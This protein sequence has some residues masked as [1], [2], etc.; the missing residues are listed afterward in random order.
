L[1]DEFCAKKCAPKDVDAEEDEL[2]TKWT[3]AG[4]GVVL[5]VY[6]ALGVGY[7]L[8]TPPWQNPDEPAHYNYVAQA[9]ASGCCPV[10]AAGDWDQDYLSILTAN[11][12]DP[13][14]LDRLDS[15]QYEDHQPPL[16][17]LMGVLP[18]QA[19]DLL[20][21]RLLSVALGA[22]VIVCAYAV[23]RLLLPDRAMLALIAA[24]VVA[25][26]PQRVAMM[27]SANNDALAE[28]I[29]G[30]A[31]VA[32]IHA[33][34]TGRRFWLVGLIIGVGFLTKITVYGLAGAVGIAVLIEAWAARRSLRTFITRGLWIGVPALGLGAIWWARNL[35]TYGGTDFLGL[36]AHDAVVIGQLRTADL[37]AQVGTGAYWQMALTTTF[38]SFWGQFGWMAL[39]LD[40]RIYAGIGVG[41]L[42]ALIGALLM[43]PKR[44]PPAQS[45]QI[46]AYAGLIAL[47]AITAAQVVYYNL[48]FVQFQG[49]YLYPALIPVAL[50][51]AYGWDGLARRVRLT[52][53]GLIAPI[54]LVGLNLFVLWRVI[55][56]LGITP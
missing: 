10:I 19:G 56:G 52:G 33:L 16:Y 38:Q 37:V 15:V 3:G 9:A 42:L 4:L 5:A 28:L 55:P 50:A 12:F 40:G 51:L 46:G 13:A 18:Y 21:L 22:G 49:R 48:T 45:W 30:L 47:T 34:K 23:G 43:L 2:I 27:A 24:G 36:A 7:A 29:V 8:R 11:K 53:V 17:Y 25:F 20:G 54:L 14:L 39:P 35:T 6:L 32:L 31:L 1:G 41:L 26:L 44:R